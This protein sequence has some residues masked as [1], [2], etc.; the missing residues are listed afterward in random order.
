MHNVSEYLNLKD[1]VHVSQNIVKNINIALDLR[2][3]MQ[4]KEEKL[5][6]K[7]FHEIISKTPPSS[8]H[9]LKTAPPTKKRKEDVS[10]Q[11]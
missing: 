8:P 10:P 4:N 7:S 6:Y 11:E 9:I 2:K 5:D 1:I 3:I